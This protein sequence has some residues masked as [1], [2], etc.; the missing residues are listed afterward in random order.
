MPHAISD[1]CSRNVSEFCRPG[2]LIPT[3][4]GW[5]FL[6]LGAYSRMNGFLPFLLSQDFQSRTREVSAENIESDGFESWFCQ[7][8]GYDL[9]VTLSPNF[10]FL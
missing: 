1:P 8:L 3:H 9:K 2:P 10:L 4:L 5:S 7:P 6:G